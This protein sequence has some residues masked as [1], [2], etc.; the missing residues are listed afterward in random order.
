MSTATF[1]QTPTFAEIQSF[2]DARTNA[3]MRRQESVAIAT[4]T[5]TGAA[6]QAAVMSATHTYWNTVLAAGTQ[7]HVHAEAARNA[8]LEK[9]VPQERVTATD[10]T[11][12][13]LYGGRYVVTATATWGGGTVALVDAD[14]NVVATFTEN[15]VATVNLRYGTYALTIDTATGVS[16]VVKTGTY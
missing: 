7:Y 14:S 16:V 3:E 2:N 11:P 12:F 6:Q 9:P 4:A 13:A 5:L 15:A 8:L 1:E 10:T